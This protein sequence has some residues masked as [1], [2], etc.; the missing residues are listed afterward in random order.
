MAGFGGSVQDAP[1]PTKFVVGVSELAVVIHGSLTS[2]VAELLPPFLERETPFDRGVD[3]VNGAEVQ[4][5]LPQRAACAQP[6]FPRQFPGDIELQ[7]ED[8]AL[9]RGL[10]PGAGEG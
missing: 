1:G 7:V 2:H 4:R 9:D 8:A 6:G 10:R 5:D 3:V